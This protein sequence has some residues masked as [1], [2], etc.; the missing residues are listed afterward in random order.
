MKVVPLGSSGTMKGMFYCIV[1]DL[2]GIISRMDA[3]SESWLWAIESL[4]S[5]HFDSIIF[6]SEDRDLIAAITK[7]SAW[8]SLK[9]YSVRICLQLNDFLD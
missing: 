7:P 4:K 2:S 1:E 9:F 3:S 5:L 8:L 6:S